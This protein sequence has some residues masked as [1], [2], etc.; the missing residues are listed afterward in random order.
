MIYLLYGDEE[1]LIEHNINKII[2]KYIDY[3]K[4][5]YDLE[6]NDLEEVV[7]E[8]NTLGLFGNKIIICKNCKFLSR[9]HSDKEQNTDVLM[10]YLDNI[11]PDVILIF[12]NA[13]IDNT[14]K[15]VKKIKNISEIINCEKLDNSELINIISKKF[16]KEGYKIENRAITEL[17]NLTLSDM[18]LINSEINKLLMYKLD[19]KIITINDVKD[20]VSKK[21][22]D[23]IFELIDAVVENNKPKI[24]N[25]YNELVNQL[26]YEPTKILIMIA[27]QFRLLMQTKIMINNKISEKEIAQILGVHPYRIKLANQKSKN[28]NINKL[29]NYLLEL[30]NID[31]KIKSGIANKNACLELFFINL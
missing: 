14:K 23:N 3:N 15:I 1:Y 7:N 29:K 6:E 5:E 24:F 17:L 13:T 30:A 27:N 4:I 10:S 11:N 26:N 9:Q 22:E 31:Y 21:V 28:I 20:V 18:N 19:D 25:L 16:Y 2:N 8:A 12:S